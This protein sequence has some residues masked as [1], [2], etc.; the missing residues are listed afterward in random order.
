M[1]E[2]TDVPG[3][4]KMTEVAGPIAV[5][6][7]VVDG[8][9]APVMPGAPKKRVTGLSKLKLCFGLVKDTTLGQL[10]GE[11]PITAMEMNKKVWSFIKE[12]NLKKTD[13]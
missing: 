7:K 1:T 8:P 9:A 11:I 3:V 4:T 13:K 10:F 5:P 2:I 12:H 6:A